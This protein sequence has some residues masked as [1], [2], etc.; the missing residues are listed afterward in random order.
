LEGYYYQKSE[1]EKSFISF[2][3]GDRQPPMIKNSLATIMLNGKAF[4]PGTWMDKLAFY[5]LYFALDRLIRT[6][7]DH[8]H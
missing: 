4:T 6:A 8:R 2:N 1:N 5:V 7:R 3:N